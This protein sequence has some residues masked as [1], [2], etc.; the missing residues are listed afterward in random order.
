MRAKTLKHR[1]ARQEYVLRNGRRM[2]V[3]EENE[4]NRLRMKADEWEPLLPEPDSD[5]N[6][7]AVEY[8]RASLARKIIRHR[9]RVGLTQVELA[10]RA[11]IRPETL[12]R[13]E[14]GNR[15][16]AIGTVQ[17]IDRALKKA[18]AEF[19][20]LEYGVYS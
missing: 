9:R 17:K 5:G 15:T 8:A 3:L 6:Y 11:G 16:P 2:V 13:I 4:Y 7:P 14:L 12:C 10:R 18:E 1:L 20:R 19:G